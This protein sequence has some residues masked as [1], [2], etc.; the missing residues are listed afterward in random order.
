MNP[1]DADRLCLYLAQ[2]ASLIATSINPQK[3]KQIKSYILEFAPKSK[4]VQEDLRALFREFEKAHPGMF[5][6][7]KRIKN[8]G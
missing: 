8:R 6:R 1:A 5:I 7:K 2:V 4:V 3:P